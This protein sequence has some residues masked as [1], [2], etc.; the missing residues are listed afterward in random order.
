M[1]AFILCEFLVIF[2]VTVAFLAL[3]LVRSDW[4]SPTGWMVLAWAGVSAAE[5]GLFALSYVVRLP[6]WIFA[7]VFG[8]TAVVAVHRLALLIRSQRQPSMKE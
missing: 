5:A 2:L 6:L 3:Y 1:I 4:R 7:V 8:V